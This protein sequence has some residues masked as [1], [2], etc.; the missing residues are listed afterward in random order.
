MLIQGA[1]GQPSTVSLQP[2]TNPT[3][4]QGQLGDIIVNE[5]HGRYYETAYRQNVFYAANQAA[6]AWSVALATTYTGICLSNP[7]GNTKNLIPT[8]IGFAL[9]AAP[10][11]I[12]SIGIIGGYLSTGVVTH[13]TPLT[14]GSTFLGVGPTPTGK[15][16]AAATIVGTPVWILP[17]MGGFT[18]AA[19]PSTSPA[20]VDLEGSIIIPPGGYICIGALT[21]VTGFGSIVWEEVPI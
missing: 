18:A 10:A 8:K 21:A 16:D 15:A 7:A 3:F 17:F 2:G 13:T 1:V 19:L 20:V 12:A 9:S 5:L 14:P 6:T 11:A 4:R